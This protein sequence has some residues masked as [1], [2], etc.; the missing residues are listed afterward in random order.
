MEYVLR[1]VKSP[2]RILNLGISGPLYEAKL[3][4]PTARTIPRY[5]SI[6]PKWQ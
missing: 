5:A 3:P 2:F 4:P 1:R 6:V